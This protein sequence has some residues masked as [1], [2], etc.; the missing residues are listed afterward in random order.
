MAKDKQK[1]PTQEEQLQ[2][3]LSTLLR[4]L[5]E[6]EMQALSLNQQL[7]NTIETKQIL[8][9]RVNKVRNAL[10]AEQQKNESK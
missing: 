2:S 5:G 10:V 3:E 9:G 7:Q 8:V 4:D 6:V 1:E